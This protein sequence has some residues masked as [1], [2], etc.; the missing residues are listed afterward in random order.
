MPRMAGI[1]TNSIMT[2]FSICCFG[3]SSR[4]IECFPN[5]VADNNWMSPWLA[6]E[7]LLRD[8]PCDNH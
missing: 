1:V 2:F 6:L 5:S 3:H 4:V 8:D 7:A